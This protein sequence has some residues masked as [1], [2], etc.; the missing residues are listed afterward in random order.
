MFSFKLSPEQ[1]L[2]R[3]MAGKFCQK[4]LEP[5]IDKLEKGEETIFPL[6]KRFL[7]EVLGTSQIESLSD[8]EEWVKARDFITS[9]LV[10]IEVSKSL[11]GFALSMGASLELCFYAILA[12]GTQEQKIKYALP[13]VRGDKIG[14][15]ALTEP[16]AGSDIRA[17]K[18]SF[19]KE[20]GD[21]ILNGQK[22]FITNAPVANIFVVYA[23]SERGFSG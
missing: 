9:N 6:I 13:L 8:L 19:R 22:T 5:K 1:I 10:S 11:P 12:S 23:N 15:W 18:T 21:Y 17:M 4:E 16:E 7:Q 3:E 14:S 2:S 20:G